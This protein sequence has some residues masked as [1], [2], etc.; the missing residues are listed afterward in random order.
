M[1]K[2]LIKDSLWVIEDFLSPEEFDT[3]YN[4]YVTAQFDD[5]LHVN[6]QKFKPLMA[7]TDMS[8]RV[9]TMDLYKPIYKKLN[10]L[11]IDRFGCEMPEE[12]F[13]GLNMQ[14]KRFYPGDFYALHAENNKIY[15]DMVYVLYL[16]DE[17]DGDIEFPSLEDAKLE[18]SDGFQQMTEMFD[19]S[20]ADKTFKFTPKKNT[21]IVMRTGVA[22]LVRPCSGQRHSIAGWPWFKRK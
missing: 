6:N 14:Y 21:C 20:F 1:Y 11:S 7:D 5:M 9:V 8:Y 22:H 17:V 15:G 3:M 2:E 12:K 4:Q 10:Q 16:S 13:H 19:V 18:W